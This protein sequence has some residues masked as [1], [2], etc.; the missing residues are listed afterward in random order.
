MYVINL[1]LI[2]HEAA[3]HLCHERL[4]ML[5]QLRVDIWVVLPGIHIRVS[6]A[7]QSSW[8]VTSTEL[9]A[10]EQLRKEPCRVREV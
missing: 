1:H 3:A 8:D 2:L 5:E 4:M 10:L 7:Q 9:C 6:A